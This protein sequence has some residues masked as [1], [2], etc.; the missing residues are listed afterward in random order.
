MFF[1]LGFSLYDIFGIFVIKGVKYN[2]I[3]YLTSDYMW[4]IL[5]LQSWIFAMKYFISARKSMSKIFF[6]YQQVNYAKWIGIA[7][8]GSYM[9]IL[10]LIDISTYPGIDYSDSNTF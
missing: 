10:W 5:Y 6:T 3:A 9:I 4:Y 1:T 2:A 7:F 8:Y